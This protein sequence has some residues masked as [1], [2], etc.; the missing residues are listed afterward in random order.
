MNKEEIIVSFDI[1]ARNLGCCVLKKRTTKENELPEIIYWNL[2]NILEDDKPNEKTCTTIMKSGKKKGQVCSRISYYNCKET[3]EPVCKIHDSQ[4][5]NKPKVKKVKSYTTQEINTKLLERM[6]EVNEEYNFCK[7]V[8]TVLLELQ[9]SFNPKMKQLSHTLYSWFLMEKI[10]NPENRMKKIEFVAAKNK[11]KKIGDIYDGPA[12]TTSLKGKYPR[13]KFFSK[14][15]T[16]W[17][18]SNEE[19]QFKCLLRDSK[20]KDD[21]CD[22]YLQGVWFFLFKKGSYKKKKKTI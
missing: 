9:P 11:L 3:K 2:I 14:E 8:D 16:S 21:L 12:I 15:Y 13:T 10:K 7:N 1:G 20:K 4:K 5:R 6:N 22:S 17:F 19:E 18:I